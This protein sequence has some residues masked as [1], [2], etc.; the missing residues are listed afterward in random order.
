MCFTA[1]NDAMETGQVSVQMQMKGT[2]QTNTPILGCAN[3]KGG[4]NSRFDL[5]SGIPL[6][7]QARLPVSFVSRFD[8]IFVFLD[9]VNDE[10]D[11]SIMEGMTLV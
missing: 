10:R 5:Y 11:A 4:D 6:I 8:L 7:E 1:L 3:P 2:I 9:V